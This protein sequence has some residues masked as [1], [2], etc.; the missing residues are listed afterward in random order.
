MPLRTYKRARTEL[1]SL[2]SP[3][4][5]TFSTLSSALAS[6][7]PSLTGLTTLELSL[8]RHESLAN[9]CATDGDR[10]ILGGLSTRSFTLRGGFVWFHHLLELLA[11]WTKLESLDLAVVRGDCNSFSPCTPSPPPACNLRDLTI[12]SS[13]LTDAMIVHILGGQKGLQMLQ[14]SLPGTAGKAWTAIEKVVPR[15]EVLRLRD[16]WASKTRQKATKKQEAETPDVD[17]SQ[18]QAASPTSPLL[19]L[20]KAAKSLET[21]LL[22]PTMLPSLPST[23]SFFNELL[24]Y[25]AVVDVLELDGFSLV[26]PLFVAL[27]TALDKHKLPSLERIVTRNIA[28]GKKGPAAKAEKSFE[29]ACRKHGVQ[30]VTGTDE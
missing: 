15:I 18:E 12:H 17:D 25:I 30:W 14:I 8:P 26:S 29:Q 21:L 9:L 4:P 28:K 24:P 23:A 1:E 6:V 7:F 20:L 19:P 13:T 16:S 2:Y 22:T 27:E 10:F 3:R 5:P 11:T